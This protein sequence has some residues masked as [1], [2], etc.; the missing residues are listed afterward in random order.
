MY[1]CCVPDFAGHYG[2]RL[3]ICVLLY[4]CTKPGARSV[5]IGCE[6]MCGSV[7]HKV[8]Y[9]QRQIQS[10]LRLLFLVHTLLSRANA[11]PLAVTYRLPCQHRVVHSL[12]TP[13][14]RRTGSI[15]SCVCACAG[16][17]KG[18]DQIVGTSPDP[19]SWDPSP[20]SPS[21]AREKGV[22]GEPG[23]CICLSNTTPSSGS[24]PPPKSTEARR[25]AKIEKK[26]KKEKKTVRLKCQ[27][28]QGF[29]H[30]V[31]TLCFTRKQEQSDPQKSTWVEKESSS[32]F[33][34]VSLL[35]FPD[36]RLKV[37]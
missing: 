13:P 24:G 11:D 32:A 35:F 8:F 33:C 4:R 10:H 31:L 18:L 17:P 37:G 9:N 19:Q 27:N 5:K 30:T 3:L 25:V 14:I 1:N 16:P 7:Y 2:K 12:C 28:P 20:S 23:L 34:C 21:P 6:R 29:I 26:K 36:W 22:P 15:P